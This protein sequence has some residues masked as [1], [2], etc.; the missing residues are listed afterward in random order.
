MHDVYT[1]LTT[2]I[3]YNNAAAVCI[4]TAKG[5]KGLFFYYQIPLG[6]QLTP[7]SPRHK[8]SG[9]RGMGKIS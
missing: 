9:S 8:I 2:I 1:I 6:T 4:P 3:S 7:D 5:K